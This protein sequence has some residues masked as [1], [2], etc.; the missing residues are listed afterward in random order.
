MFYCMQYS[1]K[2]SQH[3]KYGQ[4][5]TTSQEIEKL[6]LTLHFREGLDDKIG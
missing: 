6:P 4:G 3:F 1:N 5:S 2:Y